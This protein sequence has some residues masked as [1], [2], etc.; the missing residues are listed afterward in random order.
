MNNVDLKTYLPIMYQGIAEVE[1]QQDALS[2]EINKL[3]ATY[4]QALMDQFVQHASLK[5]IVYYENIFNIVGNPSTESLQFRRERVLSRIKMLTPPYTY[6]YFRM[7]LDGFFGKDKYKLSVDNDN[8]TITLES[9]ANDSLWYHEIQVS[10]TAVK[11]CNMIFI[12]KPR[13]SEKLLTNEEIYSTTSIRNYTLD[14]NWMLGLRPFILIG[15][16]TLN[17]M[18]S[19]LSIQQ[20]FIDKTIEQ[21][22]TFF[23]KSLI[24]DS[25]N[26]TELNISKEG[27][28][29]IVT[30]SI[31][32]ESV[33]CITNIKLMGI[34]NTILFNSN[35]FIPVD[36]YV[37]IKHIINLKEGIDG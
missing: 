19:T 16:E 32:K 24:N 3:H 9:S 14:G 4:Q 22:Q 2:I 6:W 31:S 28:N 27:S 10:I 7:L 34:D 15:E 37:T 35:V 21:W 20:T 26:V 36:D 1:A 23:S 5:A 18:A 29:L 30:Y 25:Y 8:F 17:K 11:P 33:N 13:I 12:N